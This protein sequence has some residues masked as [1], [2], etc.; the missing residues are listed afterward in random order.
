M[1]GL[2]TLA[3]VATILVGS[4][5]GLILGQG[6][7]EKYRITIMQGIA[8]CVLVIGLQMALKT[9]NVMV[10]IVSL[11]LGSLVGEFCNIEDKLTSMGQW[12]GGK[13]QKKSQQ[14]EV[15]NR[16]VE[17]FVTTS[18]IFCVGAMAI[19]GALQDG[20]KGDPTILYA[21]SLMDGVGAVIFTANFGVGVAFSALSIAIY[22]GGITL[23]ASGVGPYL[24]EGVI[25][26]ASSVGG[27][28]IVA[29]SLNML[30]MVKIRLGNMLPAMFIA[31]IIAS[32]L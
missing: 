3:N 28:L 18:L 21:K 8:L 30:G 14:G 26:A 17:G 4:A 7:K 20:L 9:P 29:I 27:I 15:E 16:F 32:F 13:F 22:Q 6:I 1:I 12:L 10:D 19:V 2:G 23:L 25:G 11:V 31:G 24:T 5:I